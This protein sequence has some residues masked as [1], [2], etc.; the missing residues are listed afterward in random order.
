M[1]NGFSYKLVRKNYLKYW[2]I[3]IEGDGGIKVTVNRTCSKKDIDEFVCSKKNWIQKV[4]DGKDRKRERI[5][6]LKTE[7]KGHVLHEG[8]WYRIE[9][10]PG[11]GCD[12]R[13]GVNENERTITALLNGGDKLQERI[14]EWQRELLRGV[15]GDAVSRLSKRLNV[16][17]NRIFIRSQKTRWG[18]C[19][20][21][22]NLSFN[23]RLIRAPSYIMEYVVVHEL[24]HIRQPSHSR[25][26]WALVAEVY[27]GYKEARKWFKENG[28]VLYLD[29]V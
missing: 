6:R 15:V 5:E 25:E 20:P 17:Y 4:R 12:G 3:K 24:C 10:V 13:V 29:I 22:K 21:K 7:K 9:P 14:N 19:S 8:Q 2:R 28:E 1:N 23:W 27:P 26:F 11:H 16:E 18:C